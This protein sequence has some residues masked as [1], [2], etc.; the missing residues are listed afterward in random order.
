MIRDW[1]QNHRI[2]LALAPCGSAAQCS[3]WPSFDVSNLGIHVVKNHIY[4]L[5]VQTL[6]PESYIYNT[7]ST[8]MYGG[9]EG[10]RRNRALGQA[11]PSVSY[12]FGFQ[13]FVLASQ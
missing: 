9:G 10:Y 12:Q 7:E 8:M 11:W 1:I 3:F 6:S 2:C 13:T 5:T 4:A